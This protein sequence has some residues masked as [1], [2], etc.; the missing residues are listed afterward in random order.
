MSSSSS[1]FFEVL[2]DI[3]T[4]WCLDFINMRWLSVTRQANRFP[5]HQHHDS[6]SA[7]SSSSSSSAPSGNVLIKHPPQPYCSLRKSSMAWGSSVTRHSARMHSRYL[8]S[9]LGTHGGACWHH[10]GKHCM[11]RLGQILHGK[12][13]ANSVWQER[14]KLCVARRGQ[15]LRGKTGANSSWQDKGKH[16]MV[17]QGQIL[18]GKTGANIAW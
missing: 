12:T 17:R 7:T 14:G 6:T 18:H 11:A 16:C 4:V 8:G 1:S 13:G 3:F 9:S 15:R 10:R 5:H 2:S